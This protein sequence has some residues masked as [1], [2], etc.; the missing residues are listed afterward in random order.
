ML[1]GG[2]LLF[3]CFVVRYFGILE[4]R[5][6]NAAEGIQKCKHDRDDKHIRQSSALSVVGQLGQQKSS[7]E[8]FP[9]FLSFYYK[10][11]HATKSPILRVLRL[12][13]LAPILPPRNIGLAQPTPPQ[14]TEHYLAYNWY[15][16]I[17]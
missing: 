14:Y 10:H 6:L 17:E 5:C 12:L 11:T 7:S 8:S 9:P 13:P 2:C 16:F 4:F 15:R 3:R 1:T